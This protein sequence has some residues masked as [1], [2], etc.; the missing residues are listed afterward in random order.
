MVTIDLKEPIK[1]SKIM[2]NNVQY[3]SGIYFHC[4]ELDDNIFRVIYVGKCDSFNSRQEQH[5]INYINA[6]YSLFNFVENELNIIFIPNYD[7]INDKI[8]A[9][10]NDNIN[11]IHVVF[12]EIINDPDNNTLKAVEGSIVNLLYRNAKTRIYLLNTSKDYTLHYSKISFTINY[13]ISIDGINI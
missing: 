5:Y 2:N 9:L 12:G 8:P 7:I 4:V 13:E 1:L 3:K 10:I 6:K 11:R